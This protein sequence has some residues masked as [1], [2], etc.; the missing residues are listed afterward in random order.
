MVALLLCLSALA[1]SREG[2]D[3]AI[4]EAIGEIEQALSDRD[5]AGVRAHLAPGFQGGPDHDPTRLDPSG[6]QRMLAGYF[7]RYRHIG[8]LVT[9]VSVSPIAHDPTQAWSEATVTL[10]GAQDLI[11]ESG[12][13]L[14]VTGL[15]REIDGEWLLVRLS[16]GPLG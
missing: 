11:P 1:C 6:V 15:W 16:W 14:K 5:N 8:V 4:R 2:P 10:A 7:L 3:Q 9:G 12:R 13:I